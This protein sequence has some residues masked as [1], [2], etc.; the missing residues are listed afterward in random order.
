MQTS[1]LRQSPR[2]LGRGSGL[3]DDTRT[4]RCRPHPPPASGGR[5]NNL[6]D[7]APDRR[8]RRP[9]G[10]ASAIEIG[11]LRVGKLYVDSPERREKPGQHPRQSAGP[12]SA[13][14]SKHRE[15]FCCS[16]NRGQG[17]IQRPIWR[18]TQQRLWRQRP[19]WTTS[20]PQMP[21]LVT[22]HLRQDGFKGL[23]PLK[24]PCC[25]EARANAE[26]APEMTRCHGLRPERAPPPDARLSSA[27]NG[28][29]HRLQP[30][31]P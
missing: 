22:A 28:R 19:N 8:A 15:S 1:R 3:D 11:R 6:T 12:E 29:T 20:L 4:R 7:R 25:P 16:W 10:Y 24:M 14:S 26:I 17:H 18:L 30:A 5:P 2:K 9:C 27:S 21:M 23:R 13:S 31:T